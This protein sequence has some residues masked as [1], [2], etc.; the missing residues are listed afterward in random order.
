VHKKARKEQPAAP[1]A[2]SS[3]NDD[4]SSSAFEIATN[5]EG[6]THQYGVG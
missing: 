3:F 1:K 5:T 2:E 4:E 6:T